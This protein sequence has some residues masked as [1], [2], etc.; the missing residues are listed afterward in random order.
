MNKSDVELIKRTVDTEHLLTR[1]LG[2]PTKR[3]G[4]T[5]WWHSPFRRD[6]D[7][8]LCYSLVKGIHDFGD[9]RHYDI[10]SLLMRMYN[11]DFV[12]AVKLVADEYGI[13]LGNEY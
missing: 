8:S 9:S 5:I 4:N 6:S 7:A 13:N 2:T 12:N 3:L 10:F 1:H 11:I